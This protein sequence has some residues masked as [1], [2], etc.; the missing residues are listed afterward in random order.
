MQV[1]GLKLLKL[2]QVLLDTG[3]V[4]VTQVKPKQILWVPHNVDKNPGEV[5][6]S[7]DLVV[8][9]EQSPS[10][11]VD[12][13]FFLGLCFGFLDLAPAHWVFAILQRD[14]IV[15]EDLVDLL[16]LRCSDHTLLHLSCLLLLLGVLLTGRT[17]TVFVLFLFFFVIRLDN[18][19]T[20]AA[21][22]MFLSKLLNCLDLHERKV[23]RFR[24]YGVVHFSF[25]GGNFLAL[26]A[27]AWSL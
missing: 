10:L 1:E 19:L 18:L 23:K 5:D 7:A 13:D 25:I 11:F 21:S 22:L 20:V 8:L 27:Y 9:Q 14:V 6:K 24:L 26:F 15:H 4:I 2:K 3:Q 12:D 17:P 16:G